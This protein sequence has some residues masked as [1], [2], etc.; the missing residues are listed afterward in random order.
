MNKMKNIKE[1]VFKKIYQE[2]EG[3]YDS[4]TDYIVGTAIDLTLAEVG[5]VIDWEVEKYNYGDGRKSSV[6]LFVKELKQK[7]GVK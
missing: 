5:K 1:K 4:D 2:V 7:L 6:N 3:E